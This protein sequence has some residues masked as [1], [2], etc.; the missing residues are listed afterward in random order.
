[1]PQFFNDVF[2]PQRRTDDPDG[3]RVHLTVFISTIYHGT[4]NDAIARCGDAGLPELSVVAGRS[5]CPSRRTRHGLLCKV[6]FQNHVGLCNELEFE[7]E[8]IISRIDVESIIRS[9]FYVQYI[10]EKQEKS[11]FHFRQLLHREGTFPTS[12]RRLSSRICAEDS[13][14]PQGR[15]EACHSD[16][17][18]LKYEATIHGAQGQY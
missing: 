10:V 12:I 5:D 16:S 6:S 4:S 15:Q 3:A 7:I 9:K 8:K 18:R 11:P 1:M 17:G 13:G 2:W 14:A